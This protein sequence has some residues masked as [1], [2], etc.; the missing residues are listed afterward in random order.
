MAIW[1]QTGEQF[2]T[3]RGCDAPP[4]V[5]VPQES[6]IASEQLGRGSAWSLSQLPLG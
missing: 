2:L 1:Y 5:A 6:I 3:L 4:E